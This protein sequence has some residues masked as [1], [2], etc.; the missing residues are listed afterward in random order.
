LLALALLNIYVLAYC[1]FNNSTA[2]QS[3]PT[4]Y[5]GIDTTNDF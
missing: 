1:L 2:F 5:L 3:F 4:I